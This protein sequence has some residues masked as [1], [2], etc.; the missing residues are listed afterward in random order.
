LDFSA[1]KEKEEGDEDKEGSEEEEKNEENSKSFEQRLQEWKQIHIDEL[2]LA[3]IPQAVR[4]FNESFQG[5]L[6]K[7]TL[8][9]L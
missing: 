8:E 6:Q 5:I 9:N 7:M 1:A 3:Y 2:F 4:E